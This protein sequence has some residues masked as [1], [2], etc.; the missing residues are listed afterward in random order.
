[1]LITLISIAKKIIGVA[2]IWRAIVYLKF[3]FAMKLK[4]PQIFNIHT[5]S[6]LGTEVV[7]TG[8]IRKINLLRVVIYAHDYDNPKKRELRLWIFNIKGLTHVTIE[9]NPLIFNMFIGD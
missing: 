5:K 4:K 7:I 9:S 1:L 6:E 8:K 2:F 3:Y